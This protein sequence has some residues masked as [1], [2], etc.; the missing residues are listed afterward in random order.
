V[1]PEDN[2]DEEMEYKDT[3]KVVKVVY[4][5]FDSDS[6]TDEHRKTLHVMYAGSWDIVS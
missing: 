4:D 1:D 3:K 2:K 5:H 6:S